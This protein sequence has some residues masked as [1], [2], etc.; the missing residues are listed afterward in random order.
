MV[1]DKDDSTPDPWAGIEDESG[2]QAD[3]GFSFSFDTAGEVADDP[4]AGAVGPAADPEGPLSAADNDASGEGAEEPIIRIDSA[5]AGDPFAALTHEAAEG[6]D[7]S[8]V[9]SWLE[10]SET[11]P[12][13]E[14]PLAVFPPASSGDE[15]PAAAM[16]DFL[17]DAPFGEPGAANDLHVVGE[18]PPSSG[19]SH[20]EVGTG[21]SGVVSASEIDPVSDIEATDDWA[22][23]IESEPALDEFPAIEP[24]A[25]DATSFDGGEGDES[26]DEF[27]VGVPE[28]DPVVADEMA[29]AGAAVATAVA[30]VAARPARS[31]G[32][33]IGQLIGIVLGGL[34]AIPI[35]YAIL[36]WGFQR[37]PFKLAG[38]L[39]EQVASLLPEKVQPGF[40]KSAGVKPAGG[41]PLDNLPTA[42][43]EPEEV[44]SQ[45]EP[46]AEPPMPAPG[47][48]G[49]SPTV[50][51]DPAA[52][53]AVT[54]P[55][56]P[57]EPVPVEPAPGNPPPA[58]I[59][60]VAAAAKVPLPP[61][62]PPEPEPLDLA[63][64]EAAVGE[65]TLAFEE[66]SSSDPESPER[67]KLLVGW[68]RRLAAV[69]EQLV[70]LEKVATDSGR[71]LDGALDG[72][73]AIGAAVGTDD[74]MQTELGKLSGMW[75]TSRRRPADGAVLLATFEGARQV[76][77][78][79]SSRITVQGAE[80]R[81]VAVI[82]RTEPQAEA[83][84][85]VMVTGVLFDGDVVW[86]SDCRTLG[87]KSAPAEDLF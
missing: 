11:G 1:D 41:S 63:A 51:P 65:A 22:D 74:A 82:S 9:S 8:G 77:P 56:T 50:P 14:L 87:E 28:S 33:G 49:P 30:P 70:L 43:A 18:A 79:W 23:T 48:P 75:L 55:P 27:P 83:G 29:A 47:E 39:P 59:E 40:R 15:Q 6:A 16:S 26:V 53:A 19:S 38:M 24:A 46:A 13:T 76:G 20:V 66:V 69:A 2:G 21:T 71:S 80:P 37:D 10:E 62:A 44:A 35:T 64:L 17:D 86:A 4:F 36:L 7:E 81:S 3:D 54:P 67:R 52:V 72:V 58:P 85:T 42:P 32:G 34:M 73:A 12:E 57:T 45:P 61:V 68:Y 5:G 84:A 25:V 31:Q 60:D 78:Y